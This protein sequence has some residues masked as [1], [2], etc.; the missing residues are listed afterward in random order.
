MNL[1]G[2]KTM[3]LFRKII[4]VVLCL[5]IAGA[6]CVPAFAAGSSADAAADIGGAGT[7]MLSRIIAFFKTV[8]EY[9]RFRLS[10]LPPKV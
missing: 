9:I 4:A 8:I 3:K 5:L 2:D 7:D 6:V 10:I 1:K